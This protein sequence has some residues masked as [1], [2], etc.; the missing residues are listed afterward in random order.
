MKYTLLI[1]IVF[2]AFVGVAHAQYVTYPYVTTPYQTTY[3]TY[4]SPYTAS[5]PYSS[6]IGDLSVGSRGSDVTALQTWLM[7]HGFDIPAISSG[8]TAPGY[9]G[10][11]TKTAL[12]AYQRAVGLPDTGIF[13][14]TTRERMFGATGNVVTPT[15]PTY[16]YPT[17]PTPSYP[18]YPTYPQQP[19]Y[20]TPVITGVEGPTS[21]NVGQVGT[22]TI[23][24]TDNSSN[25][26]NSFLTYTVD[27]GD[28]SA[29]A[30]SANYNSNNA[31]TFTHTYFNSG[32]YTLRIS[33]RNSGNLTAQTVVT[34]YVQG[35]TSGAGPLTIISPNGGE[36]L[37]RGN[38]YNI[39][40]TSP[41]YIRATYGDI[42]LYRYM[43]CTS[44]PCPAIAYAPY[45]IASNISLSQ[46]TYA[47]NAGYAIPEVVTYSSLTPVPDGQYTVGICERGTSVCDASDGVFTIY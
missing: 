43:P 44:N 33:V 41:N 24:A 10:V 42:R 38:V 20:N 18:T 14:P 45:T 32:T 19:T 40:W 26:Y 21:L 37:R 2:A 4:S 31:A 23:R 3:P 17:Y 8:Q 12:Q 6:Y 27:W 46:N 11:Q 36:T 16:Q 22:W 7:G 35:S 47:W 25:Y 5:S 15:Y 13:G 39:R 29:L 1:P 30:T 9:F 28:G 34:V